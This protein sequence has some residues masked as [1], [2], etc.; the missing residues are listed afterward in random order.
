MNETVKKVLK[1]D[2]EA[3]R[4]LVVEFGPAVRALLASHISDSHTIDD[5]AQETFI[6][7]YK[8]LSTFDLSGDFLK[9]V[10]GIARNKMLMHLRRMYKHADAVEQLRAQAMEYLSDKVLEKSEGDT[11][12]EVKRLKKCIEKLRGQINQIIKLRYFAQEKIKAIAEKLQTSMSAVG[13]QLHRGRK[14]LESCMQKEG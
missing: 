1:G 6:S 11:S 4:D 7:A 14:Q 2:R 10:R 3:F 9:W 12:A 5:L 13:V 8:D